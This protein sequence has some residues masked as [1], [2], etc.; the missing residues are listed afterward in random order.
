ML[1]RWL[2]KLNWRSNRYIKGELKDDLK[3]Q[4]S[5]QHDASVRMGVLDL[6]NQSLELMQETLARYKMAG[7]A[8]DILI[9]IARGQCRFYEFSRAEE[10]IQIGRVVTGRI[11]DELPSALDGPGLDRPGLDKFGSDKPGFDK[12]VPSRHEQ[13]RKEE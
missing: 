4:G 7:Y 3:G 8:P 13:G 6:F 2:S 9:P 11:L 10:M 1:E 5:G 12:P